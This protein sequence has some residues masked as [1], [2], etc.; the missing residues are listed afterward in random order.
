MAVAVVVVN[1]ISM[2]WV[3][4]GV[5]PLIL[6]FYFVKNYYL[7]TA[8]EI[9]RLEG[10]GES[11]QLFFMLLG[12]GSLLSVRLLS[13]SSGVLTYCHLN[14]FLGIAG[15]MSSCT[16]YELASRQLKAHFM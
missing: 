6:I 13:R 8:R 14:N 11:S 10:A 16:V 3:L 15:V 4:V 5:I 1:V 12:F 7:K 2:P 9:K